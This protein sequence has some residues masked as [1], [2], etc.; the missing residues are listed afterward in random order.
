R[1]P[2]PA[3]VDARNPMGPLPEWSPTPYPTTM[4]PA[5]PTLGA[6]TQQP[7]PPPPPPTTQFPGQPPIRVPEQPAAGGFAPPT[8]AP[9]APPAPPEGEPDDGGGWTIKEKPSDKEGWS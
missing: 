3:I 6:P 2:A 1:Q 9:P 4:P 7:P 8:F 5:P